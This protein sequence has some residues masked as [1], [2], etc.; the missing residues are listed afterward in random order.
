MEISDPRSLTTRKVT[1]LILLQ[2]LI[3]IGS[4]YESAGVAQDYLEEICCPWGTDPAGGRDASLPQVYQYRC[5]AEIHVA[6]SII[7]YT[8]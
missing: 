3:S 7:L 8:K 1:Q 6:K 5:A 2:G 4:P